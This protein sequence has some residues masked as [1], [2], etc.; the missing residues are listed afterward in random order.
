MSPSLLLRICADINSWES[1][2]G[3]LVR[4]SNCE[5]SANVAITKER[6]IPANMIDARR[7]QLAAL[8]WQAVMIPA[9]L[10]DKGGGL[11]RR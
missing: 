8:G 4:D 7:Q 6:H 9:R 5:L 3:Q 10:T 11:R 2:A 1:L